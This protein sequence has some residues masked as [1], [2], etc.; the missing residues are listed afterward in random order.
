MN[1]PKDENLPGRI[2]EMNKPDENKA[3]PDGK[4]STRLKVTKAG[5]QLL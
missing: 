3:L 2:N 1:K 5:D 4:I